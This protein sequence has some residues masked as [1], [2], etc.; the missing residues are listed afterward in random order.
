MLAIAV[1]SQFVHPLVPQNLSM[2]SSNIS[3]HHD[4]SHEVSGHRGQFSSPTACGP[5]PLPS[6]SSAVGPP[7]PSTCRGTSLLLGGKPAHPASRR[8]QTCPLTTF[9]GFPGVSHRHVPETPHPL[10]CVR[11]SQRRERYGPGRY[12]FEQGG[13]LRLTELEDLSA[14]EQ[15]GFWSHHRALP[16]PPAPPCVNWS[17]VFPSSCC[18]FGPYQIVRLCHW[19]HPCPLPHRVSDKFIYHSRMCPIIHPTFTN[20]PLCERHSPQAVLCHRCPVLVTD[21]H[22]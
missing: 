17:L 3:P 22:W 18:H 19:S 12:R 20:H 15:L 8:M 10:T 16:L 9:L 14:E 5:L 2:S 7:H 6:G 13:K 4:C 11:F 1:R 21:M